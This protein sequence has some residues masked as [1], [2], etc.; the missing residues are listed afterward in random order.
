MQKTA[1]FLIVLA[2]AVGTATVASAGDGHE[3][4]MHKQAAADPA[5]SAFDEP[6]AVGAKAT[7]PVSGKEFTI[8][9]ATDHVEYGGGH[10]Y[11]CCGGCKPQ[12]EK[13]PA[14][15]TKEKS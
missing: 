1:I 8:T 12:F 2:L 5:P 13:D 14:A 10:Y 11:F 9:E 7:C 3:C 4:G 15:Y 6:Q